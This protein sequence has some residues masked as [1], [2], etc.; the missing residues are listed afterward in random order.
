MARLFDTYAIIKEFGLK[1]ESLNKS[2]TACTTIILD[3]G[4]KAILIIAEVVIWGAY[5]WPW[6]NNTSLPTLAGLPFFYWWPLV[7][8]PVSAV[9][10]LS[11]TFASER[12]QVS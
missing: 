11:Y 12:G 7:M 6:Y 9:L 5:L 2:F 10:L 3:Q 4:S 8:F 1:F